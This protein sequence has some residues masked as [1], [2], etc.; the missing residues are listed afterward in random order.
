MSRTYFGDSREERRCEERQRTPDKIVNL[1]IFRDDRKSI[2]T[3]DRNASP[4]KNV[5]KERKGL[6]VTRKGKK[7][8][9]ASLW[10]RGRRIPGCML[11]LLT[12]KEER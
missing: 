4:K 7:Y 6:L 10:R 1:K 5:G 2:K 11:V 12:L 3:P 8:I 9:F